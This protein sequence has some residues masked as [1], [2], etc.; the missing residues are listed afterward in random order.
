MANNNLDS[1]Y[2]SLVNDILENGTVSGDRTGTGTKKV[3]GRQI[4]HK[5]I[6]G[7]PILTT[8]KMFTKGVIHELLWF[9]SGDTNT[10]YLVDNN[11]YIWI[12]DCYKFYLAN[13]NDEKVLTRDEFINRIKT[14]DKDSEFN[15]KYATIGKGYGRQWR[16]FGGNDQI[17]T[18]IDTLKTNPSSR[19][20]L[21]NAWNVS[22]LSEML[23]VPCHYG[24]QM[25]TR[26]LSI[27]EKTSMSIDVYET[28]Y[29]LSL[30]WNQRSVDTLLGLPFNILSYGILLLMICQ[31]VD[32]IP[33]ELIGNLGDTHVYLN[34]IE[35]YQNSQANNLGHELPRIILGD[36]VL[37]I[38]DS[39][40]KNF[41]FLGKANDIFSY[42]IENFKLKGYVHDNSVQYPLSN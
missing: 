6:D 13:N 38:E 5:M 39:S 7:L 34:Q 40:E 16:N 26:E 12:G 15:L 21:V 19:R 36:S 25:F 37:N 4:R 20:L 9:L 23:L 41:F 18:L 35:I 24:F 22:E 31:Q 32:M 28:K 30:M 10:K 14:E 29:E 3:F 1:S 17:Q 2:I 11:V 27:E 8:K 42:N 33:G